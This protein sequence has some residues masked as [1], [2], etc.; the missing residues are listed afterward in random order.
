MINGP[1]D[2]REFLPNGQENTVSPHPAKAELENQGRTKGAD[3]ENRMNNLDAHGHF[4]NAGADDDLMEI[5]PEWLAA[6]NAV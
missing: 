4:I 5:A 3:R 1:T 2:Q 6:Q